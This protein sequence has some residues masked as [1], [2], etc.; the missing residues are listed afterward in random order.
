[1]Q[2]CGRVSVLGSGNIGNGCSLGLK[3]TAPA[4]PG[5]SAIAVVGLTETAAATSVPRP[6]TT[7]Y[8]MPPSS[9]QSDLLVHLRHSCD[10]GGGVGN[11]INKN[12]II[13]TGGNFI[14]VWTWQ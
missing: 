8:T 7:L 13:C 11:I 14:G 12:R 3:G 9:C 10:E 6:G 2:G 1:M 4:P 5:L